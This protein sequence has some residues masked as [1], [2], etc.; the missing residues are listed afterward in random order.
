MPLV[1][2]LVILLSSCSHFVSKVEERSPGSVEFET[3]VRLEVTPNKII[4]SGVDYFEL[5]VYEAENVELKITN[6]EASDLVS[7]SDGSYQA[8]VIPNVGVEFILI[9]VY[10]NGLPVVQRRLD[11]NFLP[12]RDLIEQRRNHSMSSFDDFIYLIE[13]ELRSKILMGKQ[14]GFWLH[15]LGGNAMV[16]KDCAPSADPDEGFCQPSRKFIFQYYDQARQDIRLDIEELMSLPDSE[17]LYSQ[18][19]FFPRKV[20]PSVRRSVDNH[21]LV[22]LP[23]GEQILFD[24]QTREIL[25]GVLIESEMKTDVADKN[26]RKFAPLAYIGNGIVI[27]VNARGKSPTAPR[28]RVAQI[29]GDF[30]NSGEKDAMIYKF[31]PLTNSTLKCIRPKAELWVEFERGMIFKFPT[32]D[33]LRNYLKTHCSFSF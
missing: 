27:R 10:E 22:T 2:S 24:R 19:H 32:D 7:A 13:D 4:P 30:G 1:F 18:L 6:G 12:P 26:K 15:N 29:S 33:E 8:N 3:Q 25:E 28:P 20:I 11:L 9:E 21:L 23:T 17:G 16:P 14:V 5:E 31:D